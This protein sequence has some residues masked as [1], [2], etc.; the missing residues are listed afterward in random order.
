MAELPLTTSCTK[1]VD[2][3]EEGT[4]DCFTVSKAQYGSRA[5]TQSL[6]RDER[7]E[8]K[9]LLACNLYLLACNQL[10]SDSVIM[11]SQQQEL[12]GVYNNTIINSFFFSISGRVCVHVHLSVC[13]CVTHYLHACLS[14][15]LCS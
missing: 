1:E 12:G 2:R 7:N 15:C 6:E 9:W 5:A 4:Q 8:S 3:E 10:Y 11:H 14:V 13:L